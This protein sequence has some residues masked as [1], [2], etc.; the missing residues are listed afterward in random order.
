[1]MPCEF[2]ASSRDDLS[3]LPLQVKRTFGFAIR[4]AQ[5]GGTHPDAKPLKGFGSAG[6]VEIVESFQGDAYRAIYTVKFAGMIYVLHAFQKKSKRGRK[7][8]KKDVDLIRSRLRL[9]EVEYARRM[10]K[11]NDS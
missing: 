5:R 6:V 11:D 8:D 7:T 3:A 1:M 10:G 2:I 4:A 9:A